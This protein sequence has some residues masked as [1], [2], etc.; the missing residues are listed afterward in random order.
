MNE[1][2]AVPPAPAAA[3]TEPID[4]ESHRRF[5]GKV[6]QLAAPYWKS[7]EKG[8]AWTL[9][10]ATVGLTLFMVFMDVQFNLWQKN[11]YNSL[12]QKQE[13]AFWSLLLYFCGLATVYIIAAVYQVYLA[14][15]LQMRWRAWLTRHYLA[16]WMKRDTFYRMELQR[17]TDNPDQRISEDVRDFT[18]NTLN[19]TLGVINSVVTLVSFVGILW[20]VSGPLSFTLKGHAFTIP[21]YMV[22]AAIIYAIGG[23]F[24]TY[25][26]GRPLIRLSNQQQQREA[27]FRFGLMR[28]REN[29]EGVALYRGGANEAALSADRFERV[30]L[31]WWGLMRYTKRLQFFTVGYTQVAVVFPFWVAAPRFFGGA[32]TLG[33]LMQIGSAFDSVRTSLSWFVTNYAS[34]EGLAAWKASVDRLL[35]FHSVVEQASA[36]QAHGQMRVIPA[37]SSEGLTATG[38]Q[39]DLPDGRP[40]IGETSLSIRRGDRVVISGPSGSGKSTLFRALSGIWPFA[41]GT[42]TAPP[43]AQTLFLPQKPYIPLGSLRNAVIYPGDPAGVDDGRIREVLN[44][45]R[46]SHLAARLDDEQNWSLEL[47]PGEQQRLAIARALLLQPAWVFLDE[48]TAALDEDTERHMYELLRQRLP[49]ATLVSIAHRPQVAEFHNRRW[50]LH[51]GSLDTAASTV[52]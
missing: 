4:V 35:T 5:L 43:R 30:R 28:I 21:G 49:G 42:L 50:R 14:S 26:L 36:L 48:A 13:S 25:Y 12:E 9:L 37:G 8:R 1:P 15:M 45:V 27:D 17:T 33:Q 52:A 10:L 16:I 2:I 29:A 46:L 22:F 7:E 40:L 6:W 31:N 32:I 39:V 11:F 18:G 23:T 34:R 19:L 3:P 51:E 24:I 44:A 38:L 20:V 47:S 41:R